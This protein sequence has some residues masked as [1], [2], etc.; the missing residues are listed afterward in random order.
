MQFSRLSIPAVLQLAV[1]AG[2]VHAAPAGDGDTYP[3]VISHI[4]PVGKYNMTYWVDP[5]GTV[6]ATS[7]VPRQCGSNDVTCS[8]SNLASTGICRQLVDNLNVG[9][10]VADSPRAICLGQGGDQCCVSWN[11]AVGNMPRALLYNAAKKILDTCF[12]VTFGSGL[13]RN[14]N[15]N[16]QCVTECLSNRPNGC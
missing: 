15:L 12:S 1:A 9:D 11:R 3:L 13:A 16:G 4:V 5:P 14:V 6:V 8:G 10:N 7:F 2:F